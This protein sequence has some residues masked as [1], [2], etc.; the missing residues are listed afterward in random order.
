MALIPGGP[1]EQRMIAIGV[2]AIALAALYYA[3]VY[4]PK[5]DELA[6]VETHLESL[7]ANNDRAKQEM[8]KGSVD[9]LRAQAD[10]YRGNLEMMRQ[11]V[12]TG[13]EVPALL[14]QVSTAARRVGLDIASVEPEAVIPGETF[15][16]Y[17]YKVRVLGAYHPVAEFLT[18]VGSLRRIIAPINLKLSPVTG[19]VGSRARIR[20]GHALLDAQFQL[21]TYVAR[22]GAADENPRGTR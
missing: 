14:E 22:S 5:A 13:N 10:A 21:Q 16:T 4:S 20:P 8:A 3:F 2:I 15:D 19:N 9:Q 1:R 7:T 17:R 18:N 12:P 11:L 6:V